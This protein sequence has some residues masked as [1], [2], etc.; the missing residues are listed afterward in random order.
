MAHGPLVIL[1][2]ITCICIHPSQN[3]MSLSYHWNEVS[4][5]NFEFLLFFPAPQLIYGGKIDYLVYDYLAEVTMSLLI[6]ARH[7]NSVCCLFV[8]NVSY[9]THKSSDL[10]FCLSLKLMTKITIHFIICMWFYVPCN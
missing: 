7:K 1:T 3:C 9:I 5:S 4:L 6:G 8:M 10:H 2:L